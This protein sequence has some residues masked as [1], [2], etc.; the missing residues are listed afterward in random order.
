M[1]KPITRRDM[2]RFSIAALGGIGVS[3]ISGCA[4]NS[5]SS[6]AGS[7]I[8]NSV[9]QLEEIEVADDFIMSFVVMSDS[10]VRPDNERN[11]EHFRNALTDI[12]DME[13]KP[14]SIVMVGDITDSGDAEEYDLVRQIASDVGFDFD[15]D[16]IKVMGN[17]EQYRSESEPE[18]SADD[19]RHLRFME[20]AG[21][22]SIYYD[23][24]IE[25]Q[26][27]ICL[28][29]DESLT[30]SW[31]LFNFSDAQMEWLEDLLNRDSAEGKTS[32]VFCHE[33]LFDTVRNTGKGSWA[34][35]HS[36]EDND[37]LAKIV[38][39]RPN[40]IFFSGHTH[41][42]PDIARPDED[43][44]LYV[45]DGACGPGQLAPNVR[46]YA[47]GFV[48]SFGWL[49]SVYKNGVVF[50]ARDFLQH[51]WIDELRYEYRPHFG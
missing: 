43:G 7:S 4:S 10:H 38:E 14:D 11:I 30:G 3:G 24:E 36:L 17:H 25:G 41:L 18:L 31:V 15:I 37:E 2:V 35:G 20:Q 48:G 46:D 22:G 42:Y 33:P 51:S 45:N 34:E 6:G 39:G 47:T 1:V 8:K 9:E 32:Y 29:P 40:V 44:P 19:E 12:S 27:M 16:F 13:R 28:G 49:V 50:Q 21:V 23:L 5:P 26:H